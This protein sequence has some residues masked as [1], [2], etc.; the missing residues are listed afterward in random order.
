MATTAAAVKSLAVSASQRS[1][2][3]RVSSPV[4]QPGSAAEAPQSAEATHRRFLDDPRFRCVVEH[5]DTGFLLH[6]MRCG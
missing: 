4:P 3:S 6:V 2:S 5:R 1:A